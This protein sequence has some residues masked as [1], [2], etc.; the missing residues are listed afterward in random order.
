MKAIRNKKLFKI[1]LYAMCIFMLFAVLALIIP[2]S[3]DAIFQ[4]YEAI[5]TETRLTKTYEHKQKYNERG[6]CTAIA[7]ECGWCPD[8]GVINGEYCYWNGALYE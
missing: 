1:V 2:S 4:R 6:I 8:K 3:R 5:Q 7:P